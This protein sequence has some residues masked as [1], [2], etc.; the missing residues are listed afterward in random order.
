MGPRFLSMVLRPRRRGLSRFV[1]AIPGPRHLIVVRDVLD[2][3][4]P[5]AG[6]SRKHFPRARDGI[7]KLRRRPSSS[8]DSPRGDH[9]E[10]KWLSELLR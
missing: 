8:L 10:P 9:Q 3:R 7:A 4:L 1:A 2:L 5:C 6:S